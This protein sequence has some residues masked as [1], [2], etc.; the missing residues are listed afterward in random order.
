MDE[1]A[2][3]VKDRCWDSI[4]IRGIAELPD[5]LLALIFELAYDNDTEGS[6]LAIQL[7]HVC[8]RFRAIALHTPRLWS[9]LTT[10]QRID[11]YQTFISRLRTALLTIIIDNP[12][13]LR[14]ASSTLLT[15]FMD[16][17]FTLTDRWGEFRCQSTLMLDSEDWEALLQITNINLVLPRLHTLSLFGSSR[18][19]YWDYWSHW[20]MPGLRHFQSQ[21][22]VPTRVNSTSLVS[23]ELEFGPFRFTVVEINRL[24][25]LLQACSALQT[26]ALNLDSIHDTGL[27]S[28]IEVALLGRL[29]TLTIRVVVQ[30]SSETIRAIISNIVMPLL[31]RIDYDIE[32]QTDFDSTKHL[33]DI[34]PP[35]AHCHNLRSVHMKVK[36][37]A[38]CSMGIN[39]VFSSFPQIQHLHLDAPLFGHI[40]IPDL[41]RTGTFPPLRSLTLK[42]CMLLSPEYALG[43]M[44][45]AMH[46]YGL[47]WD[48]LERIEIIGD[49]DAPGMMLH[50]SIEELVKGKLFFS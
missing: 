2:I 33:P 28:E 12:S 39:M 3:E 49:S 6:R 35:M 19:W 1:K 20:N 11:E 26:L 25:A 46:R 30:S 43:H 9:T 47:Y 27:N 37:F 45:H 16:T 4:L 36:A 10:T 44:L 41:F 42:N 21:N 13:H 48:M 38:Y 5:E 29:K 50:E 24:L 14:E 18:E 22:A 40:D 32:L 23:C 7:S 17:V 34:C 31:E 15:D 8:R